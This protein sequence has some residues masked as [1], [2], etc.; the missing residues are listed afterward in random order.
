V[1]GD[2]ILA[3]EAPTSYHLC[4]RC[5]RRAQDVT[6]GAWPRLFPQPRSTFAQALLGRVRRGH[7]LPCPHEINNKLSSTN[8][9]ACASFA[10]E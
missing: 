6:R 10:R 7:H 4:G 1:W 5:Q 8:P 9:P 3:R 2:V